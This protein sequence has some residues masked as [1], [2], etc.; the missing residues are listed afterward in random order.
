M[1]MTVNPVGYCLFGKIPMDVFHSSWEKSPTLSL[2][3]RAEMTSP[4]IMQSCYM[5]VVF[6][7]S[8]VVGENVVN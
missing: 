5:K 4:V 2:G 7:W 8:A 1:C 6:L 3:G